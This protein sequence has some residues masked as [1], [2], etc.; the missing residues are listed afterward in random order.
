MDY[1][2]NVV[3]NAKANNIFPTMSTRE[4]INMPLRIHQKERG[5]LAT[6]SIRWSY[7]LPGSKA[8]IHLF[9]TT[10]SLMEARA[11]YSQ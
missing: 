3:C 7:M 2:T 5:N 4:N 1:T 11:S 10:A 8:P 9:T 6:C